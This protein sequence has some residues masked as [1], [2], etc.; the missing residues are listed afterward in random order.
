[1]NN[2]TLVTGAPGWLG[3]RLVEALTGHASDLVGYSTIG[4]RPVRALVLPS[5]DASP[6][7]SLGAESA[8]GDIRKPETL[9][10]AMQGVDTVFHCAGLIHPVRRIRE[11]FEVNTDGTRNLLDAAI[12][13][14]VQRFIFV[15]SNSPAGC[16]V[17]RDVLL[18]EEDPQHPYKAYG[19]SKALAEDMLNKAHAEGKIKV[20]IVRPCWFYG[21]NQPA[22]QSRFFRMIK[23]GKPIIFGDGKN[24]RSMSYVDNTVQ[25]LLRAECVPQA[26]GQTYWISDA[27][28]YE[29]NEIYRTVAEL[30]GVNL[31]PRYIPGLASEICELVDDALQ[32]V[33]LYSTDFHVAGEMN[34]D[35]ACSIDKAKR[36]L[37]YAPTVDL[38]E[39]MR[40]SIEWCAAHGQTF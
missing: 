22:R 14:G 37:G 30:L 27:R 2:R 24:L 5:F 33:G 12:A 6:V 18:K 1:M 17:R 9:V 10:A 16:N 34:K 8:V 39:G 19:R 15:S 38:R 26:V 21:P 25:G 4:P 11:V 23:S 35:I 13:A 40:R 36:E 28:P 31:T 20:T 29:T 32:A 3:T 7:T